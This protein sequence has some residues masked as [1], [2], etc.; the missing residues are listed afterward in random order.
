MVRGTRCATLLLQIDKKGNKGKQLAS[1][2]EVLEAIKPTEFKDQSL[3]SYKVRRREH[4]LNTALTQSCVESASSE[5]KPG[6]VLL[7]FFSSDGP[8]VDADRQQGRR[9]RRDAG[10]V[11]H[12]DEATRGGVGGLPGRVRLSHRSP[13]GAQA[14]T[15]LKSRQP[16]M[17]LTC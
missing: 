4:A 10:A 5:S 1:L 12:G 8:L 13:D 3:I 7:F 14:R 15:S 9:C 17:M 2:S 6:C 16:Y 11:G